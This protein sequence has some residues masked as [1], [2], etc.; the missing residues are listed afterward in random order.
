MSGA[1]VNGSTLLANKEEDD[2]FL[3]SNNKL[4]SI[5]VL[6]LFLILTILLVQ[7]I[8]LTSAQRSMNV[9]LSQLINFYKLS[10]NKSGVQVGNGSQSR[11]GELSVVTV[12][13][14]GM[15]T[16]IVKANKRFSRFS[17]VVSQLDGRFRQKARVQTY[18]DIGIDTF[19]RSNNF[20]TDADPEDLVYDYV[21]LNKG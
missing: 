7:T 2:V 19:Q 8:I 1:R 21:M 11:S 9:K 14:P 3:I 6:L 16:D 15:D 13:K 17:D 12:D 5:A 20:I 4:I 10:R 18:D